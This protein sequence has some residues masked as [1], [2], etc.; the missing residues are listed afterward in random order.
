VLYR[1]AASS[2]SIARETSLD[3]ATLS[4][5]EALTQRAWFR[6]WPAHDP[7][8]LVPPLPGRRLGRGGAGDLDR[9]ADRAGRDGRGNG[10]GLAARLLQSRLVLLAGARTS[11]TSACRAPA[12]K[13]CTARCSATRRKRDE[14]VRR[15]PVQQQRASLDPGVCAG[16]RLRPAVDH[17]AG[18]QHRH[19]G[20]CCGSTMGRG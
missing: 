20:R 4:Y 3:R 11:P 1:T 15:L 2:L 16:L 17:A 13:C 6:L 7:V 19:A 18:P 5:L 10:G 9:P 14:R 12:A 8:G